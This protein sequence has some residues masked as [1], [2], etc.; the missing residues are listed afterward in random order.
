MN[1]GHPMGME[2]ASRGIIRLVRAPAQ[3]LVAGNQLHLQ[4]GS[5]NM[6]LM[7]FVKIK[8]DS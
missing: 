4:S 1:G 5:K 7:G 6:V 2:R 8:Q 3:H